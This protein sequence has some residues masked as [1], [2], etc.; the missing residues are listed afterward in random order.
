MSLDLHARVL[1]V[2]DSQPFAEF[3]CAAVRE[4]PR[5]QLVAAVRD[6]PDALTST[7]ELAPEIVILDISLPTQNG[8]HVGR[9]IL[10]FAPATKIIF[11]TQEPSPEV[12]HAA[13]TL[14]GCGYVLKRHAARDLLA[15]I[16]SVLNGKTFVSHGLALPERA[17][18]KS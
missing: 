11:F 18:R 10:R 7:R 5:L 16:R 15:C 17:A 6:G 12:V 3:V 1:V 2:E 13:M 4:L 9:E 8:L 14:G